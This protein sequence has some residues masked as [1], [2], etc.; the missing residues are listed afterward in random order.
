V[1]GPRTEVPELVG[2]QQPDLLLLN[3]DDLAYALIRVRRA[4]P[5]HLDRGDRRVRGLTGP[6][7]VHDLRGARLAATGRADDARIDAE[8]ERDRTDTGIRMAHACRAAIPDAEHKA[9]AWELLTGDAEPDAQTI[10]EVGISFRMPENADLARIVARYTP[11]FFEILP[12]L[13]AR[14]SGFARQFLGMVL[15]PTVDAGPELL[16]RADAFLAEHK[17]GDAG[18][19]RAVVEGRDAAERAIASRALA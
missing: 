8:L 18:M 10:I 12:D 16:A 3:D 17:D 13:W 1:D 6:R 9:A 5:G 15:F 2:Q 7:G 11:E 19:L 14:R 4:L